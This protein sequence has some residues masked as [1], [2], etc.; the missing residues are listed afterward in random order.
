MGRLLCLPDKEEVRGSNPRAPTSDLQGNRVPTP[1][2]RPRSATF[3]QPKC[4]GVDGTE[5]VRL[6]LVVT[7]CPS[8]L[9]VLMPDGDCVRRAGGRRDA[10]QGLIEGLGGS[11]E[12]F[13]FAFGDD[14]FAIIDLPDS[15]SAAAASLAVSTTGA[16]RCRVTVLLTP[17]EV[18]DATRK[19]IRYRAPGGVSRRGTR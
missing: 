10:V 1:A 2:P 6:R 8:H 17:D 13:Y 9:L 4:S 19:T 12:A 16:T 11:L 14:V 5:R 3:L 15:A 18:D 7:P